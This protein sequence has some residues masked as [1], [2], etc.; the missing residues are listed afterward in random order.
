MR[1]STLSWGLYSE[2][3]LFSFGRVEFRRVFLESEDVADGTV[4]PGIGSWFKVCFVGFISFCSL[5]TTFPLK[6]YRG[7]FSPMPTPDFHCN[8]GTVCVAMKVS[9]DMTEQ[10]EEW[11]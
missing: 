4:A 10:Q 2:V 1:A 8:G 7:F 11:R 3:V 5:C 6:I 9:L